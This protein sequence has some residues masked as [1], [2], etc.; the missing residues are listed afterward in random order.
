MPQPNRD[1]PVL[2]VG[3]GPTGLTA[4]VE[5]SRLGVPVRIVERATEPPATSRALAVQARTLELLHPRGV[6][7]EMLRLGNRARA[8]ALHGRG[9]RLGAVE[10]DRM[11]S[12]Y[13]HILLLPQSETERLLRERLHRQGVRVERGVE[14]LSCEQAADGTVRAVL[15]GPGGAPEVL[16]AGQLIAADGAHSGV[17]RGLG[18]PFEGTSLPQ[19]YLLADLHVDG[20]IRE[21]ELSVYLAAD[22]FVAAFP[23]SGGRFRIMAVDPRPQDE[24]AAPPEIGKLQEIC[25]HVL[26]VPV[27][28]HDL[29]WSSRFRISG[30]HLTSLRVGSIFFGG[31]AAHV[32]SPAGG[33]GMNTGIQD[34]IN[35]CWKLA[36]VRSGHALTELLDTYQTDRLPVI[37]AIVRA[38]GVATRVLC[39]TDPLLHRVLTG[40]APLALRTTELQRRAT[41]AI[42]EVAAHYRD[43][44]ISAGGG[45]IGGLRAG[46]RVPDADVLAVDGGAVAVELERLHELLDTDR[47]TLLI[48]DPAADPAAIAERFAP[49]REVLAVRHAVPAATQPALRGTDSATVRDLA[50]RP[51]LLLVRPDGYLAAA[52]RTAAPEP[53]AEWLARWLPAADRA[54]PTAA[55]RVK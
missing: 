21:D 52:A 50:A 29:R 40:I 37:A 42:G 22:G 32:H 19:R 1:H 25:D 30:R 14:L 34:M 28:L 41:A 2:I 49:W 12:R 10:L 35:L 8:T 55:V 5:L 27:R 18:L 9:T 23:M 17:R 46:D 26:P 20:E 53:V 43:S 15:A 4:A 13:G 6:G 44:P 51:G 36:M 45:G 39:S 7:A 47:F 11:P 31:D 3:A 33:Q 24:G 16:T 54:K 48:A 38:T